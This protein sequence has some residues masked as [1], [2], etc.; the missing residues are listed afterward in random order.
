MN[1]SPVNSNSF[2]GYYGKPGPLLQDTYLGYKVGMDKYGLVHKCVGGGKTAPITAD[3]ARTLEI[4]KEHPKYRSYFSDNDI[5]EFGFDGVKKYP[6]TAGDIRQEFK[7]EE[8][9]ELEKRND[10]NNINITL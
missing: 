4:Q 6:I 9:Y 3:L 1:I 7:E 5:V 2:K 8:L 10:G